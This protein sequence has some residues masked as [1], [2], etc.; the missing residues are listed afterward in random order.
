MTVDRNGR[1]H[2]AYTDRNTEGHKRLIAKLKDL[3]TH[4]GCHP[5]LIPNQL[6]RDGRIPL[7]GVAHQC[8]TVRFGDDP[9]TSALDVN[10]KAHDLDNLYVVDTSFFPSLERREP[11][12]DGDGERAARRRP[13]DRAARRAQRPSCRR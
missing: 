8:G 5:T 9:E 1:I 6:I 12:A 4:L 3:L 7:A 13:P 10:C 11:G 2:V